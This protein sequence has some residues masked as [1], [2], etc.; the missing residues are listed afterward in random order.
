LQYEIVADVRVG[1]FRSKRHAGDTRAMSAGETS[2]VTCAFPT[3]RLGWLWAG[4]QTR[5]I[6]RFRGDRAKHACPSCLYSLQL[7]G[8]RFGCAHWIP[9]NNDLSNGCI[10]VVRGAPSK[11]CPRIR[12]ES[13]CCE[14]LGFQV[15]VGHEIRISS[16]GS[17]SKQ[18]VTDRYIDDHIGCRHARALLSTT[19][20][21]K[22][23]VESAVC[24][25]RSGS[26]RPSFAR[27]RFQSLRA[28]LIGSIPA[29]FHHARSSPTR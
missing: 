5:P 28:A 15:S 17:P 3:K 14:S 16:T 11:P 19:S 21:L 4:R 2:T 10:V 23:Q 12:T 9:M 1:S 18:L 7:L 6:R 22:V 24:V 13:A 26:I 20:E 8:S 27:V 29:C 25:F